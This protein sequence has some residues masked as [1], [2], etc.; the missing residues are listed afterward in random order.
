M[1]P[2]PELRKQ[3][4]LE[5]LELPELLLHTEPGNDGLREPAE[6]VL[7]AEDGTRAL[8]FLVHVANLGCFGIKVEG[9]FIPGFYYEG[10]ET[11]P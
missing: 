3:R 4:L 9:S 2:T 7:P 6:E 1:N 11:M 10:G 5:M 8:D